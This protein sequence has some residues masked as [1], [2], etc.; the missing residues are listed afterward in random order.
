MRYLRYQVVD[1][2]TFKYMYE[3]D[4][5]NRHIEEIPVR[6]NGEV[7][8]KALEIVELVKQEIEKEKNRNIVKEEPKIE[9]VKVEQ[10]KE[11]PKIEEVKVEQKKEEP[12]VEVKKEKPKKHKVVAYKPGKPKMNYKRKRYFKMALIALAAA[13]I[14]FKLSNDKLKQQQP[15]ETPMIDNQIVY[16]NDAVVDGYTEYHGSIIKEDDLINT[17]AVFIEECNEIGI[18]ISNGDAFY[19]IT[20]LNIEPLKY[21]NP[22]LLDTILSQNNYSA[23][24]N[25]SDYVLGQ[26]ASASINNG[27]SINLSAFMFDNNDAAIYDSVK[28]SESLLKDAVMNSEYEEIQSII[29]F[30]YY[31]P[32]SLNNANFIS[33]N[34]EP[35]NHKPSVGVRYVLEDYDSVIIRHIAKDNMDEMFENELLNF[36]GNPGTEQELEEIINNRVK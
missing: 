27:Y 11:E 7:N 4:L 5:K 26:L 21:S 34:N 1:N 31:Q 29:G 28:H 33:A 17:A 23:M 35:I 25:S 9:E 6:I 8:P 15:Q 18:N 13:T 2:K 22:Q 36:Q 16:Q 12:K 3:D 14:V 24:K 20:V 10:K 30:R 19:F 32:L